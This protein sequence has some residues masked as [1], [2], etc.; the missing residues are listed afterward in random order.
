MV[1]KLRNYH[2]YSF[3]PSTLLLLSAVCALAIVAFFPFGIFAQE[4]E[5]AEI[6]RP[7]PGSAPDGSTATNSLL[8]HVI[9]A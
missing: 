5:T 6:T 4:Q 3:T 7:A 8:L 2:K 9:L 1:I